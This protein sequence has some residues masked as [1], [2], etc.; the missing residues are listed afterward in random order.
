M[1]NQMQKKNLRSVR[2]IGILIFTIRADIMEF[3]L[4]GV[5][6]NGDTPK[7]DGENNGKPF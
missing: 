6:L 1:P 5:S 7:M 3:H 4:M 2:A